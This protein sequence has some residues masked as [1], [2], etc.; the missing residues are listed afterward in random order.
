MGHINARSLVRTYLIAAT[1]V[2]KTA[3]ADAGSGEVPGWNALIAAAHS[4]ARCGP[5]MACGPAGRAHGFH[6]GS[7][8]TSGGNQRVRLFWSEA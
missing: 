1:Y 8:R 2:F 4:A 3:Q 6:L 7:R 5:F